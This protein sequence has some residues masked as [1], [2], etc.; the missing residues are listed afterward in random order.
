MAKPAGPGG[1]AAPRRVPGRPRGSLRRGGKAAAPP[2]GRERARRG[3]EARPAP[4]LPPPGWPQLLRGRAG[5][6]LLWS[7][8]ASW[9]GAAPRLAGARASAWSAW[10]RG[11][12]CSRSRRRSPPQVR[13]ERGSPPQ[14]P[15]VPR[16]REQPGAGPGPSPAPRSPPS[17]RPRGLRGRAELACPPGSCR[18]SSVASV[19]RARPASRPRQCGGLKLAWWPHARPARGPAPRA[20]RAA[21]AVLGAGCPAAPCPSIF[22]GETSPV[23][24]FPA[25]RRPPGSAGEQLPG[26]C[27][28][29]PGK[30]VCTGSSPWAL[31]S[32]LS[33]KRTRCLRVSVRRGCARSCS[34]SRPRLARLLGLSC[35]L[36]VGF[37]FVPLQGAPVLFLAADQPRARKQ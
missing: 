9:R 12:C 3:G 31:T 18:R 34:A 35:P 20:R 11:C 5:P 33:T 36:W 22:R 21:A 8:G 24:S 4:A 27:C 7:G 28:C 13:G 30:C 32:M 19:P 29:R 1:A 16:R 14:L 37:Y 6:G 25:G 26:R 23:L 17:P 2:G 15:L 10:G